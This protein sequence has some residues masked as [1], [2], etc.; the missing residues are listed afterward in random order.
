[1]IGGLRHRLTIEEE[2]RVAD[3]GGGFTLTW[4]AV[5]VEAEVWGAILP[6]S[7]REVLRAQQLATPVSH[8][9]S[10]RYRADVTASMRLTL[11]A[12]VFNIRAVV[13]VEERDRWL[14]LMCEEGVAI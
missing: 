13:N 2:V 12:R 14:E 9:V 8:C 7:G 1:M 6:L 5:A 11:G 3:G 4:Q 10:I